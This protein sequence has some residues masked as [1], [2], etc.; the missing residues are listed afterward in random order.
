M[1]A[2]NDVPRKVLIVAEH[3]SHYREGVYRN[4]DAAEGWEFT[5]AGGSEVKDGSI[6]GIP[7]GTVRRQVTLRNFWLFERLLWQPQVVGLCARGGFDTVIFVGNAKFLSTWVGSLIVRARGRKVYYWTIGWH[8]PEVG[9]RRAVRLAFYRLAHGLLLYGPDGYDLGKRHGF[10]E[11]RMQIIGN[12]QGLVTASSLQSTTERRGQSQHTFTAGLVARLNASRRLDMAIEALVLLRARGVQMRM[13]IVGDGPERPNLERMAYD[14]DVDVQFSGALYET[15]AIGEAYAEIDLTVIPEMAGLAVMQSLAH[16]VPVVT[17]DDP[18][19]QGPEFRAIIHG[20]TGGLYEAGDVASLASEIERW[21]VRLRG[22]AGRVA[23]AC[24]DEFAQNWSPK[25]HA[26]K[27]LRAIGTSR[28]CEAVW[29]WG[30]D[31][32]LREPPA[33]VGIATVSAAEV[34]SGEIWRLLKSVPADSMGVVLVARGPMTEPLNTH[35]A[36]WSVIEVESCGISAARNHALSWLMNHQP[37]DETPILFPDDDGRYPGGFIENV[38]EVS[39]THDCM[40]GSYDEVGR[41]GL[42]GLRPLSVWDAHRLANSV[43]IMA[44]WKVVKQVGPFD[45]KMGVG[46]GVVEAGEDSDFILRCM[47]VARRPVYAP[48]MRFEH[49]IST[50]GRPERQGAYLSVAVLHLPSA[51]AL[52]I[53]LRSLTGCVLRRPGHSF[54]L[55]SSGVRKGLSVRVGRRERIRWRFL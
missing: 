51:A 50:G 33:V 55:W 31:G 29:S 20:Q 19:R 13:L 42:V 22:D 43:S 5:F 10:P 45:E 4:L 53:L 25:A 54:R 9:L 18:S 21:V 41:V 15:S 34:S 36:V 44:H 30:P 1:S 52:V 26:D 11:A 47:R 49:P 40:L 7:P 24:R 8:R 2:A 23:E 16:G 35:P 14:F 3:L 12:S 27:I 39:M 32:P 46:S 28:R 48:E 37:K 6:P 17:A 38:I